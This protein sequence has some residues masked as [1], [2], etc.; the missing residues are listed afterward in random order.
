MPSQQ[1]NVNIFKLTLIS[2]TYITQYK[3]TEMLPLVSI[4]TAKW[5]SKGYQCILHAYQYISDML[6][7]VY[8][9]GE[10]DS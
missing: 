10:K 6:S 8:C 9:G 3:R 5:K 7:V 1:K 2:A 4:I